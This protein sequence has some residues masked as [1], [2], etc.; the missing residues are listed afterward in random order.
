MKSGKRVLSLDQA[1]SDLQK[2][3]ADLTS[4]KTL[5]KISYMVENSTFFYGMKNSSLKLKLYNYKKIKREKF[6]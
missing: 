2:D 3:K 1:K 6:L 4:V 5:K